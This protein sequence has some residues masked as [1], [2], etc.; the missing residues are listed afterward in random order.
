MTGK[1]VQMPSKEV[2]D[3]LY[4][5]ERMDQD[6]I[7]KRF[8]VHRMTVGGWLKRHVIST[9]GHHVAPVVLPS[10]YVLGQMYN[11]AHMN[12]RQIGK[13][14][15]VNEGTVGRWLKYYG[16]LSV[17]HQ[18]APVALPRKA[19]LEQ[20]Y[21][22]KGMTQEEIGEHFGVSRRTVGNWFNQS[23]IQAR[24]PMPSKEVIEQMC[25]EEGMTQKQI[26][27]RFGVHKGTSYIFSWCNKLGISGMV[28]EYRCYTEEHQNWRDLVL[29]RD[30]YICQ[31]CR[32]ISDLQAH[33]I[34]PYCDYPEL[35]LD[36]DNGITIC[37]QCHEGIK[38]R[39]YEYIVDFEDIVLRDHGIGNLCHEHP[40]IIDSLQL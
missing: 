18:G 19:E 9:V 39:E 33:H 12:Q 40:N 15:D 27:D 3:Q 2:L 8:G 36:V 22:N 34:R 7:G 1:R 30:N 29:Q 13:C 37:K 28:N 32:E 24:V 20:M 6:Q 11:D 10:R 26:G 4:N 23:D 25:N 21:N 17:G 16:I 5:T 14:F 31:Q 35:E 38:G